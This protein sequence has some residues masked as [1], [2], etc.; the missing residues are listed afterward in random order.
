MADL[1]ILGELGGG[2]QAV[3]YRAY[4]RKRRQLV[5]LKV[6]PRTSPSALY[7]FKQEFRTL[8]GVSH[9]NLV[10]LYELF[11]D[12]QEW[13]FTMELVAGVDLLAAVRPAADPTS[14]SNPTLPLPL[15]RLRDAFRQL[16]EGVAALHDG[17]H[18]HRDLK[19]SNVLVTPAGRV[20]ILDMGIAV[21]LD[22]AGLHQ[23]T[24][25]QVIGTVPY[26]SP[27]QAAGR[28]DLGGERLV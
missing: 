4:D 11:S 19:P 1:E 17:G 21:E 22:R 20:V 10:S 9:P 7:R 25:P 28:P 14:T 2:G 16:A 27:E 26:M 13:S 24:E 18:V 6:L 8:A 5:A 23:S 3:V 15:D 12:G